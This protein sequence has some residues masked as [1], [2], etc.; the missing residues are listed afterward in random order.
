MVGDIYLHCK[1]IRWL[2]WDTSFC[3]IIWFRLGRFCLSIYLLQISTSDFNKMSL[4]QRSVVLFF[5]PWFCLYLK[6]S[7][8]RV[9]MWAISLSFKSFCKAG[10]LNQSYCKQESNLLTRKKIKPVVKALNGNSR[11][12]HPYIIPSVWCDKKSRRN[13]NCLPQTTLKHCMWKHNV[14]SKKRL[15]KW[16]S[17]TKI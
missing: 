4:I 8:G 14:P 9:S 12:T 11:I 6:A 17:V 3:Q 2:H 15:W 16:G 10:P 13:G 5:L 1:V 7:M